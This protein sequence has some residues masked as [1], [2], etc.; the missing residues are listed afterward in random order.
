MHHLFPGVVL[1]WP[2]TTPS[3]PTVGTGQGSCLPAEFKKRS[4]H[5]K[6][7]LRDCAQE[8]V[9]EQE[10]VKQWVMLLDNPWPGE[11][12]RVPVGSGEPLRVCWCQLLAALCCWVQEQ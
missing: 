1:C 4:D 11:S 3:R 12:R 5:T 9:C 6:Q 10:V 2:G 8:S 7:A